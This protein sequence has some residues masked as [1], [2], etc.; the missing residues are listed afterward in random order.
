MNIEFSPRKILVE[1]FSIIGFLVVAHIIVV[2]STY[3]FDPSSVYG[4][5]HL[6]RLDR[7]SNIPTLFSSM[8]LVVA[9]I[10]LAVI[11]AKYRSDDGKYSLWFVL[12]AIFFFLA[13]DETAQIHDRLNDKIRAAFDLT[14]LFYYGWVIPY[15]VAVVVFVFSFSGFLIRLPENTMRLFIMSGTIYVVGAIGIEMLSAVVAQNIGSGT[16]V[17]Q[18]TTTIEESF[19]MIGIALFI[20]ALLLHISDQF[21]DLRLTV[22]K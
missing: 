21:E 22:R 20:Y 19:E 1:L 7:E 17:Y 8:Q 10:L 2:A 4:I 18:L 6:F 5:A 13:I 12:A 16:P 3:V 15:G 9:G 14:G 11:G